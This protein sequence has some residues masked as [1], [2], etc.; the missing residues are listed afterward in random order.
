MLV[1]LLA[2]CSSFPGFLAG[3]WLSPPTYYVDTDWWDSGRRDTGEDPCASLESMWLYP[4]GSQV[5]PDTP[6]VAGFP[7]GEC[8]EEIRLELY[9][10]GSA[11]GGTT[12]CDGDLYVLEPERPLT[13]GQDAELLLRGID[14][15]QWSDFS[16]NLYGPPVDAPAD[17]L[18]QLYA[19]DLSDAVMLHPAA[20]FDTYP[21]LVSEVLDPLVLQV[22]DVQ[23]D[24]LS[25]VIGLG[26]AAGRI[27]EQDLCAQTGRL[28]GAWDNPALSATGD[29]VLPGLERLGTWEQAQVELHF[30]PNGQNIGHLEMRGM[31]RV[32]EA[33]VALEGSDICQT[34]GALGTECVTCPSG[35]GQCIE[36]WVSGIE[37]QAMDTFDLVEVEEQWCHEACDER[38]EHPECAG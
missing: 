15:T 36:V 30:S 29:L 16:V 5:H 28:E 26:E 18:L 20:V 34:M 9:V 7:T 23:D 19:L 4:S 27:T 6:L 33:G 25:V 32:D 24:T 12:T 3:R 38:E 22:V 31:V 37:A 17:M 1:L 2:G 21:M 13:G 8:D 10:E 14:C 35:A 11:V